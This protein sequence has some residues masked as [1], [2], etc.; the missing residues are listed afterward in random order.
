MFDFKK[1][2]ENLK[3][4]GIKRFVYPAI[5]LALLAAV[6]IIFIL[7]V[8]FISLNLGKTFY[9]PTEKDIRS[10]TTKINLRE[11][12]TVIKKI[13]EEKQ[14]EIIPPLVQ[15]PDEAE[16]IKTIDKKTLKIAI[17]NAAQKSGVA[18][19]LKTDLETT[20]FVVEKTDNWP[21]VSEK[22][23]VKIKE[24][25]KTYTETINEIEKIVSEKYSLTEIQTLENSSEFDVEI[26]IGKK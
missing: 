2:T 24:D 6:I 15:A 1:F 18:A 17:F 19:K 3:N 9:E 5:V 8:K 12:M 16:K 26:V 4:T 10:Q 22:T 11:F 13:G 25:K 20:G 7:S 23:I 21:E 14:P